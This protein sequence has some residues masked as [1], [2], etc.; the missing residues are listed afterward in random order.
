MFTGTTPPEVKVVLQDIMSRVS[1]KDVY[2][3]CSGNFNCDKIMHGMGFTVHS[4][5]VSLYT[6]LAAD[7]VLGKDTTPMTCTN[8]QFARIFNEWEEHPYKKLIEVMY[9]M[10]ISRFTSQKNIYEEEMLQ[11]FLEKHMA[12]YLSTREKLG[13]GAFNFKIADFYFGDF[14]DFLKA[15][16]G[17]GGIGIAFPPTYKGGYEKI[18]KAV[19]ETFEYEHAHYNLFDPKEAESIHVDLLRNDRNIVYTDRPYDSIEEFL[20]AKII[21]GKGKH[22]VYLY[23]SAEEKD[24]KKYFVERR[25]KSLKS[26]YVTIPPD[27]EFKEDTKITCKLVEVENVNYYKDFY[28]AN[29]VNYTNGGDLGMIFFADGMAFGFCSFSKMQ[30]NLD[31]LFCLADFVVNSHQA[32]LSKLLIMCELSHDTQMEIARKYGEYYKA[33]KTPVYT[34]NPVSMKYRGVFKLAKREEGKLTYIGEFGK[35]SIT[36]IYKSWLKK[37]KK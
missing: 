5:D 10:S 33:I 6:K 30:S 4:N 25:T 9:V 21:L 8:E 34:N 2:V 15:K 18:Y 12:Y 23:S 1:C 11:A 13:K 7:I 28:M 19:E 22:S 16:R 32:K 3:A 14:V 17:T 36:N 37:Y 31:E 27:F 26:K 20:T 29:K 35:E 24:S